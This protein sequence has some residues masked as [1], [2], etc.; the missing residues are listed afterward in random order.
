MT[1][2]LTVAITVFSAEGSKTQTGLIRLRIRG[3]DVMRTLQTAV[4]E[5]ELVNTVTTKQA[6][7]EALAEMAQWIP[8]GP[9]SALASQRGLCSVRR[10]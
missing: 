3:S 7:A 2:P 8:R 1:M 6:F 4:P 5:P 9:T 10:T